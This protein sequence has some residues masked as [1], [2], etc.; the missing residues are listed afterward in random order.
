MIIQPSQNIIDCVYRLSQNLNHHML[1]NMQPSIFRSLLQEVGGISFILS[2]NTSIKTVC[3]RFNVNGVISSDYISHAQQKNTY[4]NYH[5]K[6]I[7]MI[8]DPPHRMLK[9]EDM[10]LLEERLRDSTKIC[11]GSDTYKQWPNDLIEMLVIEPGLIEMEFN[12]SK[13]RRTLAILSDNS[14]SSQRISSIL[15]QKYQD[16]KV[17]GNYTEYETLYKTLSEYSVCLNLNTSIDSIFAIQS[18]CITIS[19]EQCFSEIR[20][21][22]TLEDI[23]QLIEEGIEAFNIKR[24]KEISLQVS[25]NFP[26]SVFE[27]TLMQTIIDNLKEPFVI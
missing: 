25:G 7:L 10:M 12:S 13:K 18:G 21:Y 4:H 20:Q 16:V 3:S 27:K 5:I 17:I 15:C 2:D 8:T 11:I 26:Y 23:T 6:D 1:L 9:K 14:A 19:K 24:Q 22:N